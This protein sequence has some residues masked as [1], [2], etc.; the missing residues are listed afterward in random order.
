M[1]TLTVKSNGPH[2]I[3][4]PFETM[5][6]AIEAANSYADGLVGKSAERRTIWRIKT[7]NG[8]CHM[9]YM[10]DI[11]SVHVENTVFPLWQLDQQADIHIASEKVK[12]RVQARLQKELTLV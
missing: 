10:A 2:S 8:N 4:V 11:T 3:V 1:P 9:F 5:D 7:L 12:K 6:A